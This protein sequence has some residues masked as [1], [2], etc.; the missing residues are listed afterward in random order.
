MGDFNVRVYDNGFYNIGVRPGTDDIS[1]ADV[2]GVAGLPLSQVE[3]L[4]QQ[5]CNDPGFSFMVPGRPGDGVHRRAVEL[6]Q[7]T[8][9]A[10]DSSKRRCCATS[11]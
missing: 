2:D 5:V 8:S 6:L 3:L 9:R 1:L 10:P 7:T 4:R 11:R